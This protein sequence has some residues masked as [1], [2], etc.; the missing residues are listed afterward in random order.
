MSSRFDDLLKGFCRLDCDRYN[1]LKT[2]L[3]WKKIPFT[4]LEAGGRHLLINPM[5]KTMPGHYI[6]VLTAHYDRVEGTP[7]ANDNSSSVF[8][9]LKHLEY[10]QQTDYS[11]NT[12]ILFTDKEELCGER[13]I[14][15][16][17]S[18]HLGSYWKENLGVNYF[19]TVL[20]MCGIGDTL[21]WGRNDLKLQ[22]ENP[23]ALVSKGVI[24]KIDS[25]YNALSDLLY[26]HSRQSDMGI[27]GLFSDDLGFILSGLP[28]IQFSLLPWKEAE[29]WKK[30][31][32]DFPASW[33]VNHS[34]DDGVETLQDSAFRRMDKFLKN[35]S[36]YHL[37]LP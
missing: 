33:K 19:F 36:S 32:E 2:F 30:N 26:R 27:N 3:E 7:G 12:M 35:L 13:S 5:G 37:P 34:S 22:K 15:N 4:P 8:I 20:D 6:K 24:K 16:Q 1:F 21:I 10:L 31:S 14:Y 25:L 18:Y 9:L 23:D 17:G 29:R 11:H 28:A